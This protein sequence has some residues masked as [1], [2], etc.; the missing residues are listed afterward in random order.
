VAPDDSRE[1]DI[2]PFATGVGFPLAV[3]VLTLSLNTARGAVITFSPLPGP[4]DA[5][6]GGHTEVGFT[7][8]PISGS[9]FQALLY[10]NP[11][12]SIYDGPTG[13]PDTAAL[14][15]TDSPLPF[16]FSSVD[17]SSNKREEHVSNPR[18]SRRH[19]GVQ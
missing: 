1:G 12:P 3:L 6:Y 14:Q 19:L 9:W 17:Y 5:P 18:V 4:T 15:V 13:S 8:T 10:G 7:A 16:T 11:V 2:K